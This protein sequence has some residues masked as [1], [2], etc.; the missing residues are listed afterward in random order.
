MALKHTGKEHIW[1]KKYLLSKKAD[2]NVFSGND[3]R[4]FQ[5]RATQSNKQSSFVKVIYCMFFF[6]LPEPSTTCAFV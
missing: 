6:R 5:S 4:E 1:P 3:I 2:K